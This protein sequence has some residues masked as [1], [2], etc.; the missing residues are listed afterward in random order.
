MAAK[1]EIA[2]WVPTPLAG[3][4]SAGPLVPNPAQK[5]KK[6]IDAFKERFGLREY[7]A[8]DLNPLA[9]RLAVLNCGYG[10]T[11]DEIAPLPD[12]GAMGALEWE[13]LKAYLRARLDMVMGLLAASP[14]HPG[15]RVKS[16]VVARL[17]K[18][19]KGDIG[20]ALGSIFCRYATDAWAGRLE[21]RQVVKTFWHWSIACDRAVAVGTLR[22]RMGKAQN[23][24]YIFSVGGAWHTT[25]AK[26][27]LVGGENWTELQEGFKQAEKI[28]SL[29]V[30][31]AAQD[32]EPS[33]HPVQS[34]ACTLAHFG[35]QDALQV[36]HLHS[37]A[38]MPPAAPG[39]N[40]LAVVPQFAELVC[41]ERAFSQF[42]NLGQPIMER[43]E[44]MDLP[45][46]PPADWRLMHY[47]ADSAAC[48][49][50][51]MPR[52]MA[53]HEVELMAVVRG[54]RL[55]MPVCAAASSTKLQGPQFRARVEGLRI[56][57]RQQANRADAPIWRAWVTA[58]D[59][60]QAE[61]TVV[62]LDWKAV[63]R[64]ITA[65]QWS[66]GPSK[67][68]TVMGLLADLEGV[69]DN[70]SKGALFGTLQQL[71]GVGEKLQIAVSDHG[72]LLASGRWNPNQTARP[73]RRVKI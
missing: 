24:D 63:L 16:G 64:A 7:V 49:Y 59:S 23:P 54:L 2:F 55:V 31:D 12:D 48:I 1:N 72:L 67:N 11:Q 73:N 6:K 69:R 50:I 46:S 37:H 39:K 61:S 35:A 8:L 58:L 53:Q 43:L 44:W 30:V 40:T 14:T 5:K 66:V 4:G 42:S 32:F 62:G 19:E 25:E 34:F 56:S 33:L 9:L 18:T 70:G 29:L 13:M 3:A 20:Y 51:G 52:G 41:F 47:S 21:P 22:S 27:T 45:T 15:V 65:A 10:A 36:V 57:L 28:E 60:A 26:G 17:E 38:S 71:G 68:Q